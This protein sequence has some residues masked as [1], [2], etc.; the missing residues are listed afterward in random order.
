V[1]AQLPKLTEQI[2]HPPGAQSP[3]AEILSRVV[4]VLG[5]LRILGT[6]ERSVI[7][8]QAVAQLVQ[9]YRSIVQA[10]PAQLLPVTHPL[11]FSLAREKEEYLFGF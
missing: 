2:A 4:T 8:Q 11:K 3:K 5:G 9:R 6:L 10:G 7:L 1:L